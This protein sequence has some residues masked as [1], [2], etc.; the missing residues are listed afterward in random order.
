VLPPGVC[1]FFRICEGKSAPY[2]ALPA[3]CQQIARQPP[4]GKGRG[5]WIVNPPQVDDRI[6]NQIN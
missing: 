2:G 4:I 1:T 3:D 5:K 6:N